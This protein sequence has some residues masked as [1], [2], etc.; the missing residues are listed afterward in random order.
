MPEV[1][2]SDV[3]LFNL[4][5]ILL[6][7]KQSFRLTDSSKNLTALENWEQM[8]DDFSSRK[9]HSVTYISNKNTSDQQVQ[10]L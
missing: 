6:F 7:R 10:T 3:R 4:Q 5:T 8:A 2:F 9:L 1:T